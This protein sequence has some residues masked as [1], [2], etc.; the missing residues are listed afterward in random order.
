MKEDSVIN[1]HG[2]RWVDTLMGDRRTFLMHRNALI[3]DYELQ[4]RE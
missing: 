4:S 3:S 2:S 1:L